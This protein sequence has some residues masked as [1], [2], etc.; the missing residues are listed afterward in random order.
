MKDNLITSLEIQEAIDQ[1]Q[2]GWG[3]GWRDD[4]LKRLALDTLH[5]AQLHIEAHET[6]AI[7]RADAAK[8]AA[9]A[10]RVFGMPEPDE[11]QRLQKAGAL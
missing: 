11:V 9:M 1:L 2:D 5:D 8:A 6:A 3:C 10:A 7:R 4:P